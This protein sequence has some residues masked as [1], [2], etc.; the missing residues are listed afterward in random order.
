[1][2]IVSKIKTWRKEQDTIRELRALSDKD[3]EDIGVNRYDIK[4][5]VKDAH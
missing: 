1:M 2:N 5:I 3:L 4:E